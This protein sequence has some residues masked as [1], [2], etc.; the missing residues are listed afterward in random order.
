[1]NL[2]ETLLNDSA[3]EQELMEHAGVETSELLKT[4]HSIIKDLK[5]QVEFQRTKRN[6]LISN[7]SD[8]E[9]LVK[10]AMENENIDSDLATG[11]AEAFGWEL[12][13]EVDVVITASIRA[14]LTLPI[15]KSV[16]DVESGLSVDVS[17]DWTTEN[18]GYEIS[19][20]YTDSI[21]IEEV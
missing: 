20:D 16:S 5:G 10:D 9:E 21:E 17:L 2:S 6:Q 7:I 14:T 12:T 11:L 19:V 3:T 4:A 15:G 8:A 1:M 18:E 13:K